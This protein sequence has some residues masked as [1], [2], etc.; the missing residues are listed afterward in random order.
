M[1]MSH[2]LTLFAAA[3]AVTAAV[4]AP[5]AGAAKHRAPQ[6]KPHK[7][8][9][10]PA[11]RGASG[12]A[13]GTSLPVKEIEALVQAKGT[14]SDSVLSIPI[15]RSDISNVTL[16]GVPIKPSF[17]INGDL[18]FQPIGNGQAFFN[19]DIPVKPSEI[20]PVIDAIVGSGLVMQAEHQHMY[21]FEPMVWFI[22]FRAKG[23]PISIATAVHRVLL[24]TSTPLPQEPPK[25]PTT[26]LNAGR[27]R[28]ILHGYE[29]SVGED[30]VVT[31]YVARRNPI[32]INGVVVKP[33]TNIATNIAFE[34]LNSQGSE[35]AAMPD[36][37][38]EA[39]EVDPVMSVMRGQG[40]DIGCLYNQ[41]TDEHPQLFFSH[42]FKTGDPYVLAQEIRRGL[43]QTNAQ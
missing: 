43:D 23:D 25:K 34:P 9:H 10:S 12:G 19:A 14:V 42:Q 8:A 16:H 22:H 37:A 29:A 32:R 7:L 21:D 28:Q 20:N 24:A 5:T 36:Y 6:S 31:V 4:T 39:N 17:E 15:D 2:R 30:G 18:S 26:P 13:Q 41:E 1:N 35:V 11:H 27:L 38:M 3:V 40:W 33:D